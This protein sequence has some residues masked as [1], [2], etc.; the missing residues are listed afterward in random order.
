MSNIFLTFFVQASSLIDLTQQLWMSRCLTSKSLNE[1]HEHL[2]E[3]PSFRLLRLKKTCANH[4]CST[5]QR[6]PLSHSFLS[7]KLLQ[8]LWSSFLCCILQQPSSLL[9]VP[10]IAWF[11]CVPIP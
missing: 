7:K 9:L 2:I 6:Q 8:H 1:L 5:N 3:H 10:F 4:C 11:S